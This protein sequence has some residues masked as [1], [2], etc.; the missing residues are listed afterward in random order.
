ME[1]ADVAGGVD[2]SHERPSVIHLFL[3]VLGL[4]SF[5]GFYSL[6]TVYRLLNAEFSDVVEQGL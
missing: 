3:A 5:E 4:H 2:P 1:S 6:V